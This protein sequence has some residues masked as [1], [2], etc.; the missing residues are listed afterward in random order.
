MDRPRVFACDRYEAEQQ[1]RDYYGI[2]ATP[3][4]V[5]VEPV[6]PE[7]TPLYCHGLPAAVIDELSRLLDTRS[8]ADRKG[9][10]EPTLGDMRKWIADGG[11]PDD[12]PGCD[13]ATAERIQDLLAE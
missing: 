13:P 11:D 3:H 5:A 2:A 12:V 8:K 4:G 6:K 9:L 7:D 1:F 10:Y